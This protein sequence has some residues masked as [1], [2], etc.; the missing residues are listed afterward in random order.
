MTTRMTIIMQLFIYSIPV[1]QALLWAPRTRW[2]PGEAKLLPSRNVKRVLERMQKVPAWSHVCTYEGRRGALGHRGGAQL[3][4]AVRQ[5][6]LE[7]VT[8]ELIAEGL[9]R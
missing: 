5:D 1:C 8:S 3:N 9:A 2:G 6:F 7:E 4:L